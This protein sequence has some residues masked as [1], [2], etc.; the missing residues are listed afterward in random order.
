[1]SP[2][3]LI[4]YVDYL[5]RR[6][7]ENSFYSSCYISLFLVPAAVFE[8]YVFVCR[9]TVCEFFGDTVKISFGHYDSANVKLFRILGWVD[10][11]RSTLS[12]QAVLVR[13]VL[14]TTKTFVC[15]SRRV[16]VSRQ[17][18]HSYSPKTN[19][20]IIYHYRSR[21]GDVGETNL[22]IADTRITGCSLFV[23]HQLIEF[24]SKKKNRFTVRR[25]NLL[26][27]S[28]NI[29]VIM[30]VLFNF[31]FIVTFLNIQW[32]LIIYSLVLR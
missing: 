25:A 1:M 17:S 32:Y 26:I 16:S 14:L 4:S 9:A 18:L 23:V 19:F 30:Y 15:C 7:W 21:G 5:S 2:N 31:V 29:V 13:V 11:R 6:Y 20:P 22:S 3:F 10:G 28:T 8:N 12:F 27:Q 24:M